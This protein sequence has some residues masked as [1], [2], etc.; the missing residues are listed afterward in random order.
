MQYRWLTYIVEPQHLED[1]MLILLIKF[2]VALG[3]LLDF[4]IELLR[5]AN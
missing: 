5:K 4:I 2:L 3:G 1:R